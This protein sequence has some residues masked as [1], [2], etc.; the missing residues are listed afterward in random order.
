MEDSSSHFEGKT[1]I[2][3]PTIYY[4]VP[5]GSAVA[6][7]GFTWT[8]VS[9]QYM[10]GWYRLTPTTDMVS[11]AGEVPVTITATGADAGQM[12]IKVGGDSVASDSPGVT[13]LLSR[14]PDAIPGETGGVALVG[15]EMTLTNDYT[16]DLDAF[17]A[18]L[19]LT[20]ANKIAVN[21]NGEV[22]S[23][24]TSNVNVGAALDAYGV[25]LSTDVNNV[26]GTAE[27][28][29]SRLPSGTPG[30]DGVAVVGSPMTER[31]AYSE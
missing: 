28:V 25:A 12:I 14:L 18:R 23:T 9:A 11:V 24:A 27:A 17:A 4:Q 6:A 29:L 1:G 19:L 3:S 13:E 22:A 21:E 26:K 16:N 30:V 31:S 8:E 7:V 2:T 20:P 10:A 5:E 15:S